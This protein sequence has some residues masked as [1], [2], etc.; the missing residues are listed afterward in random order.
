MKLFWAS[1]LLVVIAALPVLAVFLWLRIRKFP[2]KL[3]WLLISLLG[4]ALSL[5]GAVLLQ[6]LFPRTGGTSAAFFFFKLF[7]Q[8]A[9]TEELSRL[10]VLLP[11]L[12]LRAFFTREKSAVS[13]GGVAGTAE[14]AGAFPLGT[15]TGLL[16]GLGF[17]VVETV[18]Y[19]A[20][21]LGTALFRAFTAAPL[22]GACGARDGA[23][24]AL[25]RRKPLRALARFLSAVMIHGIYNFM[26]IRSGLYSVLAVLAALTALASALQEIRGSLRSAH[27]E[28][29]ESP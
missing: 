15:T 28:P 19:G 2:V 4:G 22:H 16:A 20:G 1:L 17:A 7:I 29:Q 13:E 26:M 8:I 18:S 3:P 23:A 11:L 21:N 5:L 12:R 24:A 9:F 14:G 6:S 25:L 27:A 10:L